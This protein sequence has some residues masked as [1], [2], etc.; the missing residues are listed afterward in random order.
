[1][2][3]RVL[4]FGM[5]ET[6]AKE[7]VAGPVLPSSRNRSPR[8]LAGSEDDISTRREVVCESTQSPPLNAERGE[9]RK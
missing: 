4:A 6:Y 3:S 5:A 9:C 1:M 2:L 8:R 7:T